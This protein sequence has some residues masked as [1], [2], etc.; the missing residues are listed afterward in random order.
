MGPERVR[1]LAR[2]LYSA[3]PAEPGKPLTPFSLFGGGALPLEGSSALVR[4]H[5]FPQAGESVPLGLR[6]VLPGGLMEHWPVHEERLLFLSAG[7]NAPQTFSFRYWKDARDGEFK[8]K[9]KLR[10][11]QRKRKYQF[12]QCESCRFTCNVKQLLEFEV[13]FFEREKK[14]T[15]KLDKPLTWR[16]FL[17]LTKHCPLC[18]LSLSASDAKKNPGASLSY[19]HF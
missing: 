10:R 6:L 16:Y 18:G 3:A 4:L 11:Q 1:R 17:S 19:P 5:N 8:K 14:P 12:L 15:S 9:K 7:L 2:D 13:P